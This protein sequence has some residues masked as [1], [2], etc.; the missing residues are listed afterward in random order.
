MKVPD[1]FLLILL[2]LAVYAGS[3]WLPELK[4]LE[5]LFVSLIKPDRELLPVFGR[6]LPSPPEK[7]TCEI[8]QVPSGAPADGGK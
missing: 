1:N 6:G 8:A 2:A 4:P 3:H 7:T 5:V